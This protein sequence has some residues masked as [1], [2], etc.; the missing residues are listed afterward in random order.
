MVQQGRSPSRDSEVRVSFWREKYRFRVFH[1]RMYYDLFCAGLL[2][3]LTGFLIPAWSVHGSQPENGPAELMASW[4]LPAAL[5][6][7]LAVRYGTW[8]LSVWASMGAGGLLAAGLIRAGLSPL[9]AVL[10]GL[11]PGLGIG[12]LNALLLWRIRLPGWVVT[13][14]VGVAVVAGLWAVLPESRLVLDDEALDGWVLAVSRALTVGPKEA[15]PIGPLVILRM[16]LAFLAWAGVLGVLLVSDLLT[17]QAP[18][19]FARWWV[20]SASLLA[21]GVLSAGSGVLWLI[22]QGAAPVPTRPVDGLAIP[23]AVVLAGAVLLHGRGR[24]M[25]AGVF[26]PMAL[27]LSRLWSEM[28]WPVSRGGFSL[29]LVLLLLLTLLAHLGF[30]WGLDH[31]KRGR[32]RAWS[33]AGAG[34]LAVAVVGVSALLKSTLQRGLVLAGLGLWVLGVGLLALSIR[35]HRQLLDEDDEA[36]MVDF[37]PDEDDLDEDDLSAEH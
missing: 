34:V 22:D 12:G 30:L 33:A 28:I 7:L 17:F 3:V 19:P 29:S 24:T 11:L 21:C 4:Q 13:G 20:R 15:Y 6:L 5:G 8:D 36:D 1:R 10:L 27:L 23:T 32:R 2:V 25:L 14:A 9:P 37:Q 16:L 18:R 26:L 35:Q 31:P